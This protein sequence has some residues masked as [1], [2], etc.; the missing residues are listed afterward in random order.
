[1]NLDR[2]LS[3]LFNLDGKV[4]V[5]TGA[6]GLLGEKHAEAIAAYGGNAILLDLSKGVVEDIA[7]KLN[8]KYS[9]KSAG[10]TV[11]ITNELQ[12]QLVEA[13]IV[14]TLKDKNKVQIRQFP[15]LLR[16]QD[17]TRAFN[18]ILTELSQ[19]PVEANSSLIHAIAEAMLLEHYNETQADILLIAAKKLFNEQLSQQLLLNSIPLD[20]TSHIK[21]LV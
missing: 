12:Y 6:A 2:D 16:E 18:I 20:L 10:F 7:E 3:N 1:M 14:L 15:A 11:D 4:I 21:Q 9:V 13:G 8:K 17:V 5:I 19:Q